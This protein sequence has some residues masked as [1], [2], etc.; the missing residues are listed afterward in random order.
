MEGGFSG[1][2]HQYEDRARPRVPLET[3]L[4]FLHF[5]P[6]TMTGPVPP[7]GIVVGFRDPW[8]DA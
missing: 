4:R 6:V 5:C 8:T 2:V 1:G 7:I 3:N